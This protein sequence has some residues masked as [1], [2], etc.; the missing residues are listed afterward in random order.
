MKTVLLITFFF[1]FT[2]HMC[3]AQKRIGLYAGSNYSSMRLDPEEPV[4]KKKRFLIGGF[5]SKQIGNGINSVFGLK[6]IEK[7]GNFDNI[8]AKLSYLEMDFGIQV[9][10]TKEK[11]GLYL[12]GGFTLG[13]LAS[14]RGRIPSSSNPI[15][16]IFQG[17]ELGYRGGAGIRMKNFFVEGNYAASLLSIVREDFPLEAFHNGFQLTGGLSFALW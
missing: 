11:G 2:A 17:G 5:T 1:F 8:D 12:T 13:G 14:A 4:V 15:K 6:Y 10:A 3:F 7:G 9:G 16:K